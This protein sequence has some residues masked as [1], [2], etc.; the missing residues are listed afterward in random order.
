MDLNGAISS[1]LMFFHRKNFAGPGGANGGHSA[2]HGAQFAIEHDP[3]IVVLPSY[4]VVVF[5]SFFV[6]L[7]EGTTM[8]Y[9]FMYNGVMNITYIT[10]T[11]L[12][13]FISITYLNV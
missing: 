5:H 2:W 3:F 4:N 11:T 7:P 9:L 8:Y 6:C 10:Y 1:T 12:S 13:Y